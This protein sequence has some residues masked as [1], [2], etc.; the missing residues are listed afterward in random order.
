VMWE[1]H[2]LSMAIPDFPGI[3]TRQSVAGPALCTDRCYVPKT[4]SW[5]TTRA[6]LQFE[7]LYNIPTSTQTS[8][9]LPLVPWPRDRLEGLT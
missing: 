5:G 4:A 1:T 6:M 9:S 7:K 3:A 8:L 2:A